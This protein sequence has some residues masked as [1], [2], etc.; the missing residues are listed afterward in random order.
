[1]YERASFDRKFYLNQAFQRVKIGKTT[2]YLLSKHLRRF[3]RWPWISLLAFL[4]CMVCFEIIV[5]SS[6]AHRSR[7]RHFFSS[8]KL[9][10]RKDSVSKREIAHFVNSDLRLSPIYF[11]PVS[12]FFFLW[13]KVKKILINVDWNNAKENISFNIICYSKINALIVRSLHM[14]LKTFQL[15]QANLPP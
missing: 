1:M 7:L 15:Q 8:F 14:R 11:S 5:L 13:S 2:I 10:K 3:F 4:N 12:I 6:N 9:N